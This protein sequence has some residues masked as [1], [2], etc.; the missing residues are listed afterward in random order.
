MEPEPMQPPA[1]TADILVVDDDEPSLR[2]IERILTGVGFVPREASSG[3]AALELVRTRTPDLVLLDVD[4]PGM[5][6]YQVCRA[7][8]ADPATKLIPIVMVTALREAGDRVRGLEA[9]ADDLISKPFDRDEL[10]GRVRSLLRIRQL[11]L[12]LAKSLADQKR[13]RSMKDH[14]ISMVVSDLKGPV[15]RLTEKLEA[16]AR[17][18]LPLMEGQAM[19][20]RDGRRIAGELQQMLAT[21]VDVARMEEGTLDLRR[22]P[23]DVIQVATEAATRLGP[24]VERAGKVLV[25]EGPES[26]PAVAMDRALILRVFEHLIIEMLKY[27]NAGTKINVRVGVPG[28]APEIRCE[29]T[30]ETG[31]IPAEWQEKIFEAFGQVESPKDGRR[32]GGSG[33]R[34][35]FCRLA[36]E[37]HGGKMWAESLDG[38]GF[39]FMFELPR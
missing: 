17:E 5:S 25:V 16:L 32:G 9:G 26:R 13:L 31:G 15:A 20:L 23:T 12:D 33:V 1:W 18:T 24:L 2:L 4:M 39:R 19:M 14:L 11:Y 6:G 29:V 10:L 3:A 36:V 35:S 37:L 28:P 30:D 7:L 8:R 27:S 38:G 22:E 34:L 21:L